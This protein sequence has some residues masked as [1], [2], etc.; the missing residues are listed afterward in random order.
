VSWSS[1]GASLNLTETDQE[2]TP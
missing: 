1:Q 2:N